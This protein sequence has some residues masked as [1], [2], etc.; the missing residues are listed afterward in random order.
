MS[1]ASSQLTSTRHFGILAAVTMV[2]ALMAD[3]VLLPALLRL[4]ERRQSR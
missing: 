2:A 4:G 1:L 3:L